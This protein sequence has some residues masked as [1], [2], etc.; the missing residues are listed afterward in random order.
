[1]PQK[2][3]TFNYKKLILKKNQVLSLLNKFLI[4]LTLPKLSQ[5]IT[6]NFPSTNDSPIRGIKISKPTK[7]LQYEVTFICG[8]IKLNPDTNLPE[9]VPFFNSHLQWLTVIPAVWNDIKKYYE[10][11]KELLSSSEK[12]LDFIINRYSYSYLRAIGKRGNYYV[13]PKTRQF[14]LDNTNLPLESLLT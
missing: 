14:W 9:K 12:E 13:E 1:M 5:E 2:T 10:E 11:N 8:E 7:K 6:V 4:D 3:I